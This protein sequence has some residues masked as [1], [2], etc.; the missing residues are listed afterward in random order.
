MIDFRDYIREITAQINAP[1]Q[2]DPQEIVAFF[3]DN[4]WFGLE[5]ILENGHVVLSDEHT[6]LYEKPLLTFLT[7]DGTNALLFERLEELF[8]MTATQLKAFFEEEHLDE[9]SQFYLLDF[10]LYRLQKDIFLYN[11]DEILALLKHATHDMIKEHG[12]WLTFFLAWLR[13]QGKTRFHRDYS[14][15][16]RYTMDIQ[17]QAYDF[18][19]YLELLYYLF[20]ADYI[21]ENEMYQRAA[22]S[23]NYTDTWLY[24]S[25]HFVGSLR[26]TDLARIYHPDLPYSPQEVIDKIK[27]GNFT[28]NDSKFVLLSITTRMCLLPFVP[29]KTATAKGV[30]S[31][32]FHIPSSC[33][34]HFG[35]LFALAEAHRQLVGCPT[36]PIIKKVSGYEEISRYMGDE[37]GGL[38][39]RSDFRSRSATK[40]YLQ[41]IYML[42][43]DVLDDA[44]DGPSIKGYLLAALARSHK[45]T[46]GEFASTTFEYLKDAKLSGLT[47]EFVAFELL[48]RGV[49][50]FVSATLLKMITNDNYSKA[51]VPNQTQLIQALDLSPREIESIVAAVNEGQKRASLVIKSILDS[52]ADILT[53]LHRLGSGQAFSKEPDCLCL[54]TAIGKMCPH[55]SR[56]QCVGCQYEISTKSTFYLMLSEYKRL[57]NLYKTAS[58]ELEKAKYKQIAQ[59]VLLPKLDE[60]LNCIKESYGE[61]VL[62]EYEEMMKGSM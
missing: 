8:P 20:N 3:V 4:D 23:K 24:L 51:S 35:R 53:I 39:L 58:N 36:E 7:A 17:N 52:D 30:G 49:L 46:Y 14:M 1:E 60:M 47:P 16:K 45:G 50:S 31:V 10:L 41:A 34:N 2:K 18:N 26:Y 15:E 56:R 21:E 43:D 48:E 54:M 29:N 13:A 11:D 19:E 40:S 6:R 27:S 32:K 22:A 59:K 25:M 42:A 12:D 37:I 61:K 28:D 5:P 9:S 55:K 57:K 44:G 62:S 38:F 33:E